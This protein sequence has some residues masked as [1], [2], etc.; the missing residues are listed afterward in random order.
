MKIEKFE[1]MIL[2]KGLHP[3]HLVIGEKRQVKYFVCL[4]GNCE[5]ARRYVLIVYDASGEAWVLEKSNE[6]LG[7]DTN[8]NIRRDNQDIIINGWHYA[9]R[10]ES[11]DLNIKE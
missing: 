8:F 2:R 6:K 3:I 1:K 9:R 10:E 4:R 5:E 7:I 11:L